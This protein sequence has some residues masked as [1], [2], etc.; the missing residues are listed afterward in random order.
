MWIEV[1]S[2]ARASLATTYCP[3]DASNRRNVVMRLALARY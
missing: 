3:K 2:L 1:I